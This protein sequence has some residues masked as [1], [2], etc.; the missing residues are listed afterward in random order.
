[1]ITILTSSR[2]VVDGRSLGQHLA[3]VHHRRS[4][5]SVRQT[6]TTIAIQTGLPITT[7]GTTISTD[8][9][10]PNSPGGFGGRSVERY[11]GLGPPR[12]S[13]GRRRA[14]RLPWRS[15]S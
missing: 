11:S 10:L 6:Q 7:T 5:R 12:V 15:L 1:M 13:P 9:I 4:H 14:Q 3:V 2:L 8:L